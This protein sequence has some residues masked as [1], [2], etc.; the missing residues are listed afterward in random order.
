MLRPEAT[1]L[2]T[3]T[4]AAWVA[5]PDNDVVYTEDLDGRTAVRIAQQARDFTT[6]WFEVGDLT[7]VTEA[8]VVPAPPGN[9]GEVYRQ[10]LF[11]NY[12]A[13]RVH[14]AIDPDGEV[15]LRG[16]LPLVH[17]S[18]EELD[19]ILAEVYELVEVAFRPLIRAGFASR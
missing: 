11:R 14:F 10:C 9:A 18:L 12:D 6:I 1:R 8:Y 17:L 4:A 5:D 19:A 13:R 2:V 15:Y 7:M 3:G 16:R